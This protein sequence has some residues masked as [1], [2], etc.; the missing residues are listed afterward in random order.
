MRVGLVGE[1]LQLQVS[2]HLKVV[3]FAYS[4]RILEPV[5]GKAPNFTIVHRCLEA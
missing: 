4:H 2:V 3:R 1:R 5:S